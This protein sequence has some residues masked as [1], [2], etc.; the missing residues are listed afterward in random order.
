MEGDI[1]PLICFGIATS[2]RARPLTFAKWQ[3]IT[4]FQH[5][6]HG[7]RNAAG[8]PTRSL[9]RF[10]HGAV[11]AIAGRSERRVS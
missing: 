4:P 1:L 7:V 11:G 9:R 6:G 8:L 5:H 3:G 10:A 2:Y